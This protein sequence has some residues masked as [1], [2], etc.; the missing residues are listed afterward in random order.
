MPVTIGILSTQ[1]TAAPDCP[2]PGRTTAA[3]AAEYDSGRRL[4]EIPHRRVPPVRDAKF[5]VNSPTIELRISAARAAGFAPPSLGSGPAPSAGALSNRQLHEHPRRQCLSVVDSQDGRA[6]AFLQ[7]GSKTSTIFTATGAREQNG[8][9][10]RFWADH[11][12][13]SGSSHSGQ[14]GARFF[15]TR[16]AGSGDPRFAELPGPSPR[17]TS[18][19]TRRSESDRRR[20][21]ARRLGT[22]G[23]GYGFT[24]PR[25][26]TP[27]E[28]SISATSA[29][30]C[31]TASA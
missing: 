26:V 19:A 29:N 6:S 1:V 10:A 14:H 24:A 28:T 8:Q 7:D 5:S 3:T 9:R 23:E 4:C 27:R 21:Q 13:C 12:P 2:P 20:R 16:S 25:A 31:S 17:T 22:H 18:A 15:L 30:R 11:C